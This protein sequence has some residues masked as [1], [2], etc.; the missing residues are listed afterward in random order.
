MHL[1]GFLVEA[2]G[3]KLPPR[4]T[5]R[6]KPAVEIPR[7]SEVRQS[8]QIVLLLQV[9]VCVC[10]FVNLKVVAPAFCEVRLMLWVEELAALLAQKTH[11][12][13]YRDVCT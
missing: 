10:V 2:C 6:T 12:V 11:Q 5:L 3:A 1:L 9:C 4:L 8:K 7:G 13:L